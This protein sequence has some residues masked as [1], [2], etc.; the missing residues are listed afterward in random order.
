MTDWSIDFGSGFG[1]DCNRTLS[2]ECVTVGSHMLSIPRQQ[3]ISDCCSTTAP[4]S[5]VS[6]LRKKDI[7]ACQSL[8]EMIAGPLSQVK[9]LNSYPSCATVSPHLDLVLFDS[10]NRSLSLTRTL[11]G[12]EPRPYPE[13][14]LPGAVLSLCSRCESPPPPHHCWSKSDASRPESIMRP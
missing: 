11:I 8:R 13:Q 2:P 4:D 7:T 3:Y 5:L 1:S 10:R 6:L 9:E 14:Q 12:G